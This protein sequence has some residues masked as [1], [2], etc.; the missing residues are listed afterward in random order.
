[1]QPVHQPRHDRWELHVPVTLPTP[2]LDVDLDSC[3]PI[4]V[5]VGEA[6]LLTGC[7]LLNGRPV[8]PLLV[9]GGRTR[10][11]HQ[12]LQTTLQ[13]LQERDA[14][15]WRF[16][17]QAEC[18]RNAL[19]DEIETATRRAVDYAAGFEQPVIVLEALE[20]LQDDLDVGPHLRRR[21]HTWAFDRLQTQLAD[22]AAD[23]GI[24]VRYVDPAYTS[25]ICHACGHIGFRPE[26]AEFRCPND[27]CWVSV[28]QADINAAANIAGRLDPW[29]ESLSL[30]PTDDDSP[31]DGSACDSTT[32]HRTP[33][34]RPGQ[35][36][37]AAY[38]S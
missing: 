13:R 1:L 36:T 27:D 12:T 24:P 32:G 7:A 5:D 26:Q 2:S 33:S 11:L 18:F 37:L 23:A 21:L 4:A 9:D 10:E 15:A 22:K 34:P 28:Y 29:G 19:G 20:S 17:Q 31:R 35:T 8:D 3:T 14:A 30:N 16:D 38:Q 25:Q 6:I